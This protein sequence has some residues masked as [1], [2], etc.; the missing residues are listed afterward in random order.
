M[1]QA[2][3]II[4][5]EEINDAELLIIF[6]LFNGKLCVKYKVLFKV[7]RM[8]WVRNQAAASSDETVLQGVKVLVPEILKNTS[9]FE[10]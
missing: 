10:F 4:T 6:D 7:A 5:L 2:P 8:Y 9:W 3:L 1:C